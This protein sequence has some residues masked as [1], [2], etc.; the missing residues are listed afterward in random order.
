[1]RRTRTAMVCVGIC[2]VAV[3]GFA[4]ADAQEEE[5]PEPAGQSTTCQ[6]VLEGTPGHEVDQSTDPPDGAEL[7]AEDGVSVGMV[8]DA[9]DFTDAPLYDVLSCVTVDGVLDEAL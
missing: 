3:L 5:R 6:D 9:E 1:M 4:S 7:R 2:G 8:W